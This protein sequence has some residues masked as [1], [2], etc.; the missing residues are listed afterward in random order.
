VP[1]LGFRGDEEDRVPQ[2]ETGG[3]MAVH[4]HP[5]DE[6]IL[7]GGVLARA[8]ADGH[9]AAVVT[10]TGGERG[11][12]V[13]EGFD[14]DELRPNLA[15]VRAAELARAL[16]ILG[17]G[18]PRLLGYRDSG[19]FG[20]EGNDDPGAFWQ[21]DFDD[22]VGRLVRH[23]RA[24]RPEVLVTYD[25]F[26]GYG[27]PDHI[28]AHRVALVAVEA[29]ASAGLHAEAGPPWRTAKVYFATIPRSGIVQI[30]R[31]LAER[32]LPSPF[33]G[34]DRPEDVVAG[35]PDDDITTVVDVRPQLER[36]LTALRAHATQLGPDSFFLNVPDDLAEAIFG[37]EAF[38]R[39]R[40]DV[41]APTPEDDL[42]AGLA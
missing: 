21:A 26:G 34:A 25:A 4:A 10:C 14:P 39:L 16:D 38:V 3:L 2:R 35:V 1:A 28:Q 32:G 6:S 41:T 27:H 42:F 20:E 24:F 8:V 22:A 15:A 11:E 13:G 33:A 37:R 23:I 31:A 5:D 19:M 29:A 12:I 40:S 18:P 30:N 17:A 36:K 9:R 7:T